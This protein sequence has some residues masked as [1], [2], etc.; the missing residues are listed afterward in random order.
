M[1]V[2]F[3]RPIRLTRPSRARALVTIRSGSSPRPTAARPRFC[4]PTNTD[5]T[6]EPP[7]RGSLFLFAAIT[8]PKNRGETMTR[9]AQIDIEMVT[10]RHCDA[11]PL[12]YL[13]QDPDYRQQDEDRLSAWRQDERRFLGIRAKGTI[14]IHHGLNPQ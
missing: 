4:C 11:H 3:S 6:G 13:F 14:K 10:E 7:T 5:Q 8:K 9:T 2:G 12:D 1:G